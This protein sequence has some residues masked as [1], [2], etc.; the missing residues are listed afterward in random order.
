MVV[1]HITNDRHIIVLIPLMAFLVSYSLC[2]II[3]PKIVPVVNILLFILAGYAAFQMPDHRQQYNRVGEDFMPLAERLKENH[4]SFDRILTVNKFDVLMYTQKPV[5]WPHPKLKKNP[6]D[7]FE[8]QKPEDLLSLLKSYQI[9]YVLINLGHVTNTDVFW[10]RNY[11]ITLVRSLEQLERQGKLTLEGI[12]K[13]KKFI[14]L[15]VS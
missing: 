13:S 5:I 15:K 14:L 6:L 12:S 7:L 11:P 10:G 8:P 4:S 9:K 2:Q 3:P 1:W